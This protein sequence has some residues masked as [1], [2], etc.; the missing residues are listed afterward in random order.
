M[1]KQTAKHQTKTARH[2]RT[3]QAKKPRHSKKR[4]RAKKPVTQ[5]EQ[6]VGAT[7]V[8]RQSLQPY[9]AG[10]L[11]DALEDTGPDVVEVMEIEVMRGPEDSQE[12][13]ETAIAVLEDED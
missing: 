12:I 8:E 5:E 10:K 13:N 7:A 3:P 4:S 1:P 11:A 2:K 6:V 9:A